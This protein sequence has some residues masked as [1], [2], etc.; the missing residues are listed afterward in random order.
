MTQNMSDNLFE[1]IKHIDKNG[2]EFWYAREFAK[3]LGYE[4]FSNFENVIQK[5][6]IALHNSG[7]DSQDHLPDVGEMVDLGSGSK[8]EFSSYKLSRYACYLI[9][10]NG[11]PRKKEIALAQTYF[12][13]KTRQ[14]ELEDNFLEDQKRLETR[15]QLRAKNKDLVSAASKAGVRNFG[16]FQDA[17]YMGLYGGLRQ[18]EIKKKK[19][20]Q[21]KDQLLDNVGSEELIANLFRTSQAEAKIK[22]ENIFGESKANETHKK[23]GQ[24]VREAIKR[25][26]GQMPETLPRKENIKTVKGRVKKL[27]PKTKKSGRLK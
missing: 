16:N 25:L 19:G 18:R 7:Y 15:E 14:K 8:R 10:Q 22:R 12:A 23:A 21:E 5:A 24:E 2:G 27:M 26:G 17:G 3:V 6:K 1:Q 4:K 11:D 20:L 13:T 9:A